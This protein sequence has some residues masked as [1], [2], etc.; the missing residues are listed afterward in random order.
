MWKHI[1]CIGFVILNFQAFRADGQMCPVADDIAPCHC[2]K[3]AVTKKLDLDCSNVLDSWQLER[4]FQARFPSPA[5]REFTMAGTEGHRV[6]IVYLADGVFGNLSFASVVIKYTNISHVGE[7]VFEKSYDTLESLTLS[8]SDL[9]VYPATNLRYFSTL[10]LLDLSYNKMVFLQDIYSL[11]L[12]ILNV[13]HNEHLA[14]SDKLLTVVPSLLEMSLASC[15]IESIPPGLFSS[16]EVLSNVNMGGNKLTHLEGNALAFSSNAVLEIILS[17]N[18]ISRA[19][20]DFISGTSASANLVLMNNRLE[21]LS[22]AVW[23]PILQ[24]LDDEKGSGFVTLDG[25]PFFCGC[26]LA[27]LVTSPGLLNY[28]ARGAACEDGSLIHDL[29]PEYFLDHCY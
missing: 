10:S 4:I 15:G 7:K 11:S 21:E 22:E 2:L 8:Y 1:S 26:K 13:E 16:A 17:D 27:W 23:R 20:K 5:F 18:E 28:V 25:N 12:Q 3:D 6:P 9:Q 29:N 14:F 19:D 24:Y